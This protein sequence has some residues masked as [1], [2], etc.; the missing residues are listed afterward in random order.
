MSLYYEPLPVVGSE[1]VSKEKRSLGRRVTVLEP[2][3]TRYG[4]VN[5]QWH[6]GRKSTLRT[7]YFWDRFTH[8]GDGQK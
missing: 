4:F 6:G 7:H 3:P 5:I 1:Y 2:A 8:V